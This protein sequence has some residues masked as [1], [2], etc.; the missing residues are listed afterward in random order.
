MRFLGI[1]AGGTICQKKNERG[2][3]V[4]TKDNYFSLAPE[5]FSLGEIEAYPHEAIDS[6][7]MKTSHRKDIARIIKKN[8]D[9]YDGFVVI[10]G[11]D[12]LAD[13][14][15]AFNYMMQ[16]LTK[17]VVL[18]G[19][20]ISIYEKGTDAK[21][22]LY[23][24]F[25]FASGGHEGVWVVFGDKILYG[26]R[27]VKEHS[28]DFNAFNSPKIRPFGI[29]NNDGAIEYNKISENSQNGPPKFFTNF[30]TGVEYYS[31]SSGIETKVFDRTINDDS[32][33]GVVLGGFG[34]GNVKDEYVPLLKLARA[35]NKPCVVITNCRGGSVDMG[36]YEVGANAL[37]YVIPGFDLTREA[38]VQKLM[39]SLG[40]AKSSGIEGNSL[41]DYVKKIIQTP[42]GN[43]L[44]PK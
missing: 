8:Y 15:A 26:S 30:E 35:K 11:T 36:I 43:D 23:N 34:V 27:T 32:V 5:I 13:S 29:I 3:L 44:S 4:P 39:F 21:R 16:D 17:P 37:N 40:K 18:T 7:N 19:S 38:A 31:Q 2:V 22:N 41:F 9:L 42:I 10:Q 14:A 28:T 1:Q 20:Q 6:T 33:K 24:S 25:K 12:S